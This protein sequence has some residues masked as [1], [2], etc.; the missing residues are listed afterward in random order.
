[1]CPLLRDN[2][3]PTGAELAA[4]REQFVS[5]F[6]AKDLDSDG[7]QDLLGIR[8]FGAKW[9]RYCVWLYDPQ[10][11][12]FVKDQLAEQIELLVNVTVNE[13]G[14]IV[15]SHLGPANPW[16]QIYRIAPAERSGEVPRLLP[17]CACL[18][19]TTA[20]GNVPKAIVTTRYEGGR[21]VVQRQEAVKMDMR[22]ALNMCS[23]LGILPAAAPL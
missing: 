23:S 11:H 4:V 7:H 18:V 22:S 8:E 15:T 19:E 21:P 2:S 17:L 12:L 20:D 6:E 5:G 10:Q 9:A 14:Q 16:Y 13:S 1:M 3:A